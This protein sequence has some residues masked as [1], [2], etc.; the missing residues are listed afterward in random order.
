MTTTPS[1]GELLKLG[2]A[3][4][5]KLR[6]ADKLPRDFTGATLVRLFCAN[7][8]L[9][10]LEL[11]GSEW[12][13]CELSKIVFRDAD[14]SNA[15]FHGGRLDDC[16]FTGA[17]LEGASFEKVRLARCDFTNARGLDELELTDV[18]MHEVIG[19][20]EDDDD[21]EDED[22]DSGAPSVVL[23]RDRLP[24]GF[25]RLPLEDLLV[26]VAK[27]VKVITGEPGKEADV[28]ALETALNTKFPADYRAF[29]MRFGHLKII[30][31]TDYGFG[32]LNVFGLTDLEAAHDDYLSEFKEWGFDPS[33]LDTK[34]SDE[35]PP[36]AAGTLAQRRARLRDGLKLADIHVKRFFGDL[37][38][39][40]RVAYQFMVPVM[41]TPDELHQ[42][43][44]CVG[45][46][47]QMYTVSIKGSDVE[48]PSGTFTSRLLQNLE[49]VV[50]GEPQK[51]E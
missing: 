1:L 48:P 34:S 8:N 36:D 9:E 23:L 50:V 40:M 10:G 16:D 15:Y 44:E 20:S 37:H 11:T 21:D 35:S 29:L 46:D 17:N 28:A 4:L 5:N 19:L 18:V 14:L 13:R 41:A 47:T 32:Y 51:T 27:H 25:R 43:V 33:L 45:P 38:D 49:N 26:E 6:K 12:E 2:S 7:A 39:K 30:G 42:S 24:K 3:E 22:D 31:N